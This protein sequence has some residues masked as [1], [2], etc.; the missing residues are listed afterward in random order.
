MSSHGTAHQGAGGLGLEQQGPRIPTP[1][2]GDAKAKR[3]L[4][5][6]PEIQTA[7]ESKATASPFRSREDFGK[8]GSQHPAHLPSISAPQAD[9]RQ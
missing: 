9:L 2:P 6:S 5:A 4:L 3:T 1:L 7:G 8:L